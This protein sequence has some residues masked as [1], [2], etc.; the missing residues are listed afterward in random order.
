MAIGSVATL[1]G[2]LNAMIGGT[3]LIIPILALTAG[4]MEQLLFSLVLGLITAYTAYLL[5]SHLG[6]AKNIKHL[7]LGH[8]GEDVRVTSVYNVIIWFSFTSAMIVYFNLFC[9][10]VEA[11][12]GKMDYLPEMLALVLIL[13]TGFLRETDLSEIILA[14]GMASIVGFFAFLTFMTLKSENDKRMPLFGDN[15]IPLTLSLLNSFTTHD[16]LIQV[17][18]SN[19][20]RSSYRKI[21]MLLY[22]IGTACFIY[23]AFFSNSTERL[24]SPSEHEINLEPS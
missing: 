3:M 13:W 2:L 10:Q 17:I 19:P 21:V 15:A 5:V 11:L 7:I 4:T 16:F 18:I 6:T 8:F 20:N 9:V 23:A 24:L 1:V 12:L 14:S 22:F